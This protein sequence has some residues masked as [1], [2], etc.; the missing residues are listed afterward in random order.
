MTKSIRN[1]V[2][3][4]CYIHSTTKL[5]GYAQMAFSDIDDW[6]RRNPGLEVTG[7]F[8]AVTNRLNITQ[9]LENEFFLYHALYGIP[10]DYLHARFRSRYGDEMELIGF[11]NSNRKYKCIMLE[12]GTNRRI[13]VTV[14]YLMSLTKI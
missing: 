3:I 4:V 1:Q 6:M 9:M 2:A 8:D 5:T 10:K 7:V 14:K 13:K 11:N 12:I